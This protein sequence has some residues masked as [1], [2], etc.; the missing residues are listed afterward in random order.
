M[1][2]TQKQVVLLVLLFTI[3]L[4]SGAV[5]YFLNN[6]KGLKAP[7]AKEPGTL[8][9][10][11]FIPDGLRCDPDTFDMFGWAQQGELPN[12]RK[13][14]EKGSYGYSRPVFPSHTP[15]NFATLLTGSTPKIHG[16]ADG[17]MHI[18]GYPLKMVSKGGFSSVAK[19]VPPIWYTMEENGLQ[20]ALISMPGSTPPELDQGTVIRGRWGGWGA[21]FPAVVF[22][23][24]EDDELRY[25]QGLDHRV[26]QFGP[27]LTKYGGHQEPQGWQLPLP[28][29]FSPPLEVGLTNWGAT[30]HGYLYDS[31]D[32]NLEAYDRV[33]FS[34]DKKNKVADLGE[35]EWSDWTNVTLY[36]EVKNDYNIATPKN[37]SWERSMSS[38][39]VTCGARIRVIKLGK[40]GFFRIRLLYDNLNNY[41]VKPSFLSE[42]LHAQLP[43][44]VDFV[45][46]YPPQLIHYPEDKKAFLEEAAMSLDWHTRVVGYGIENFGADV[47][48]HD[49]Y[50]PNQMLTSR[51][52]LG[53]LDPH[54]KRYGEVSE[55]ER[56]GLWR[57]VKGMYRQID[58][59]MG[60]VM[61][62]ADDNTYIVLSS[63]HGAVPLDFEVCLNNLFAKHGLL[64][65]NFDHQTG[66][67]TIDWAN[68]RAIFLKMDNIYINPDGLDG[69]YRRA[70]GP[71]YEALR[72]QVVDLLEGLQDEAGERPVDRI[73][74]WEDSE[75]LLDLPR[76]RVG[77][78]IV[79]NRPGYGWVE[80]ISLDQKVFVRSLKS[81][82][83]QAID[84]ETTSLLTPFVIVGPKVRKNNPL[85]DILRHID[86]YPTL[87]KL[88]G[89]PIPAFVEGRP[90]EAVIT[91]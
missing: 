8:K 35:G 37:M 18:E 54:S 83:K 70:S 69:N 60:E 15:T 66:E 57:D 6:N 56:E 17:P 40:K 34:W 89:Q 26:F 48:I 5:L 50:T 7:V 61:A 73:V 72:Q 38:I 27:E 87:M 2:A 30:L 59:I 85:P 24:Q 28:R 14:M 65:Y 21:D 33:L 44:M 47:I 75:R 42:E 20:V 11:W 62:R 91:N 36:W 53:Y 51:W 39:D 74:K 23:T 63:D 68:T 10:Y 49:T 13:M 9:L 55:S 79:A 67:Y 86:Q 32:D 82:Y 29:S 78:L 25:D 77:D 4:A 81:G 31:K 80:D 46:N 19:K 88:L 52:W 71:R 90:I 3:T 43:P 45:D 12:I 41:L 58:A 22:H 84:P 1:K 76:D 16:I 64:K